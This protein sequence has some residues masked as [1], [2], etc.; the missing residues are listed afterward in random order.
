MSCLSQVVLFPAACRFEFSS[1][2]GRDRGF[3]IEALGGG[4]PGSDTSVMSCGVRIAPAHT[5]SPAHYQEFTV[6]LPRRVEGLRVERKPRAE[7]SPIFPNQSRTTRGALQ[8]PS[9]A[10]CRPHGR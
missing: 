4:T 8:R 2:N 7:V 10:H 3:T 9:D 5:S 1:L 6:Q